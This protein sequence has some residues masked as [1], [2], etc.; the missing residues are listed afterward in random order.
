MTYYC[1]ITLQRTEASKAN[2]TGPGSL[3][4]LKPLKTSC[5]L[6]IRYGK[7]LPHRSVQTQRRP[8]RQNNPR[9]TAIPHNPVQ[10]TLTSPPPQKTPYRTSTPSANAAH[11]TAGLSSSSS[12]PTSSSQSP[13]SPAASQNQSL[14]CPLPWRIRTR[15]R[16]RMCLACFFPCCIFSW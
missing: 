8:I 6:R 5:S 4:S 7:S 10:H 11:P 1:P 3:H 12:A 16:C 2:S 15:S 14:R 9:T 13:A